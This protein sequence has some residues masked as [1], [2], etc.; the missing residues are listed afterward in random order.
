VAAGASSGRQFS[1]SGGNDGA[2]DVRV[3][4]AVGGFVTDERKR[5]G[6]SGGPAARGGATGH[7]H[8]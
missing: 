8:G 7:P 6:G 4:K 5:L 1:A 3:W 2:V